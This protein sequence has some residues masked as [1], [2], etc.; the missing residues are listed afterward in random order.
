MIQQEEL[1]RNDY[2]TT[3]NDRIEG[4]KYQIYSSIQN[5]DIKIFGNGMFSF[6]GA[7]KA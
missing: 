7:K 1:Y 5:F 6:Q 2:C 3:I 4:E